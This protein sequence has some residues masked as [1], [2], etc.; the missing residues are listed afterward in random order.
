MKIKRNA[1]LTA[2][3]LSTFVLSAV[4]PSRAQDLVPVNSI[5]GGSSIFVFRK[6]TGASARRFASTPRAPRSKAQRME[7]AKKIKKQYETLAKSEPHRVKSTVVTPDKVPA[8][9]NTMPKDQASKVFAGVGEYYIDQNDADNSINFFRE[10]LTLDKKNT[11]AIGGLSE[12]LAVKG[13]DLLLG[14]Q[15]N[16][17][18]AFFLE[19]IKYNPKNAAAYFGLGEVYTDLDLRDDAIASYEKA[20][21]GDGKLTEIFLPLGIL[22][23]QK[24]EIAKADNLLSKASANSIETAETQVLLGV[25]RSSQN[26]T[27]EAMKAFDRAMTL[28]RDNPDAYY[29][30]GDVLLRLGR[31]AEAV[32]EFQKAIA[33]RANYF[34]AFRGMGQAYLELNK[35][36]EAVL[37]FKTAVRLKNDN[38][39]SYVGLGEAERLA[40]NF[41][42][43]ESAY[44]T[45]KDLTMRNPEF[46]KDDAADL[47]SK[48]GYSIGRQCELNMRQ[49]IACRWPAAIDAFKKAVDLAGSPLDSANLG[50]AYYNA[51]RVDINSRR[52]DAARPNLELAKTALQRALSGGPQ[53]AD[54]VQQNLGGVDIDL[55]DFAAA[56]EALKP[57]VQHRPDW[58]FSKYA[59]GTAYFKLNQFDDAAKMFSAAS[60][61]DPRNVGYLASLG[62]TQ[63]KLR[64]G[65]EIK[66]IVDRLKKLDAGEATKLEQQARIAGIK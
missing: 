25:I 36:P 11:K 50:W 5:G 33:L 35:F 8:N 63:L 14:D 2:T 28:D 43:A 15:T 4:A 46:S 38:L 27:D 22:Y 34:E 55:G 9:V 62:Y 30:K 60:D 49:A 20:L 66:K 53:I 64:N 23:F 47:Y 6:A 29:Y 56:V 40:G 52:P 58:T 13:N 3:L 48:I 57:V 12:A 65:K 31:Q 54:G 37:A 42:D 18:K 45:A 44:A 26:R 41:N 19:A 61:S 21:E 16:K 1:F 7:T 24:G 39:E 10:S 59:L 51:A 17:A 32:T